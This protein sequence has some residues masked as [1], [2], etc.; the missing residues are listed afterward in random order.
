MWVSGPTAHVKYLV[1]LLIIE[2]LQWFTFYK[3]LV[4]GL[5]RFGTG[6]Q[7]ERLILYLTFVIGLSIRF[8][9]R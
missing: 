4:F 5:L 9:L 6:S 2:D 7:W 1:Y 8:I 3:L